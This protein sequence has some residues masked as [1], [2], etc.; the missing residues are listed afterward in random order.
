MVYF[1]ITILFFICCEIEAND[2]PPI[3]AYQSGGFWYFI[4][5]DGKQVFE[6]KKFDDV[7]GFSE[8][9]IRVLVKDNDKTHVKYLDLSGKV[10]LEPDFDY[11]YDFVN[12]IAMVFNFTDKT[13]TSKKFGF[14]DKKGKVV[15]PCNLN[16]A[17][18]FSEGLAYVSN[19]DYKGYIDTAGK[20]IINLNEN[21]GF[22]FS[23]GLAAVN[24]KKFEFGFIDKKGD[25]VINYRFDEVGYFNEGFAKY[26]RDNKFGFIDRQGNERIPANFDI[27]RNFSEGQAFVGLYDTDFRAFWAVIDTNGK[28]KTRH[29]FTR[30]QDYSEGLAAV[31]DSSLWGYIN[32]DGKYIIEPRFFYADS[33]RNGI[34]WVSDRISKEFGFIDTKGNFK[35]KIP[36]FDKAFELRFNRR[37]Y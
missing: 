5:E 2:K 17:S 37:V 3:L 19:D 26:N 8:G 22:K 36:E 31:R 4:D 33:F 28:Y 27:V 32:K 20:L 6:P 30:V 34:A 1:I 13:K 29:I 21:A 35:I 9:L 23:E 12:G 11:A 14:I 16:D 7:L 10:I 24:N 18:Q 15:V 25:L